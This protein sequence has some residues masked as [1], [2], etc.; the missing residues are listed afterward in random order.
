MAD[1]DVEKLIE[2]EVD[3]VPAGAAEVTA[4]ANAESPVIPETTEVFGGYPVHPA[5]A[6]LPL[7]VGE[8]FDELVESIRRTRTVIAV[9][10]HEGKLIDGRNRC[11]AVEQLKLEG[12]AIELPTT[13]WHPHAGESVEEHIYVVN[14]CRR[15]LSDDQRVVFATK[16]LPA[17]RRR[18]KERQ[19]ASQFGPG[20]KPAAAQDSAP[21]QEGEAGCR[22]T[23]QEKFENSTIG[24]LASMANVSRHKA[25]QAAALRDGVE[26]GEIPQSALDAVAA[27]VIPLRD[28]LP[29]RKRRSSQRNCRDAW[30]EAD[31]AEDFACEP[32]AGPA[33]QAEIDRFWQSLVDEVPVTE[34][35]DMCRMLE[36][37][38]NDMKQQ[39]GW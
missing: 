18:C 30:A 22:L 20:G 26:A 8:E 19:A 32:A 29:K 21:P 12:E 16:L 33:L 10:I 17:I 35:R 1:S 11:R 27:G 38:I 36:R 14:V 4:A 23:S 39:H 31:D 5:A 15:H 3:G 9:E 6:L 13:E 37:K 24:Q 25:I 34:H 28:A 7:M 2:Q